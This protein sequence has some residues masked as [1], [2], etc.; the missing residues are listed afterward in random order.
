M[1]ELLDAKVEVV[2]LARSACLGPCFIECTYPHACTV[3][4]DRVE[5]RYHMAP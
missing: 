5:N 1:L 3:R 2:V 4:P